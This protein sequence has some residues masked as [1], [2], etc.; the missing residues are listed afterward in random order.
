MNILGLDISLTATGVAAPNG[1]LCT[2]ETDARMGDA[3]LVDISDRLNL[4]LRSTP[5]ELAIIEDLPTHAHGAGK[6]AMVH[7][8]IR[9]RLLRRGVPYVLVVAASLKKYA[10]GK[11]NATKPDMRLELFKRA[12]LDLRDDNEVDAWWLRAM[13]L[14]HYGAA[15]VQLPALHRQSLTKVTWPVFERAA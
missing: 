12:G 3:R 8:L 15:A 11:G 9:E 7:G 2:W 14:D 1:Q 5:I 13:G 10:T 6:T 4:L